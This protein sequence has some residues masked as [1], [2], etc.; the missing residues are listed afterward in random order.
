[1][2]LTTIALATATRADKL[3]CT[4]ASNV[5]LPHRFGRGSLGWLVCRS[6]VGF[7][8]E[9]THVGNTVPAAPLPGRPRFGSNPDPSSHD[10]D[11]RGAPVK[12]KAPRLSGTAA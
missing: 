5:P 7:I 12:K 11:V 2:K 9:S 1:M 4:G 3:G 10:A 8:H 6:A